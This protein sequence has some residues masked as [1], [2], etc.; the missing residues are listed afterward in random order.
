MT[1]GDEN[2]L[3]RSVGLQNASS[4]LIA[5]ERAERRNEAYLAEAGRLSHTGS[6]GLKVSTGE[7]IWSEET[8][9]IFQYDRMAKPTMELALQRVHPEDVAFVKQTIERA[10]QDRKDFDHEYRLV[11]PD[12]SIKYVHIVAHALSDESGSVEFVG[13]GMDVTVAKQAEDRI[14]LII[15]AVPALIW[16]ARADGGLDFISER[17]LDYAGIN[18]GTIASWEL[19]ERTVQPDY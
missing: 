17:W 7:I 19:G 2:E 3:L 4:I 8:F 13:A 9:R 14:R 11:M 16:T 6:C 5:R 10:S 12:G 1:K 18:T 15:N